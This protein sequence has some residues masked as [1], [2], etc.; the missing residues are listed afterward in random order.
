MIDQYSADAVRYWAASTGLGKDAI[1]SEEKIKIGS[2]LVTKIWNV[3]R[4][5]EQFLTH[6]NPP[7]FPSGLSPADQWILSRLQRLIERSTNLY[8]NYDYAT[9]KSEIETFFWTEFTDNYLE[10][11][12]QRLYERNGTGYESALYTLYTILLTLLKMF[13]PIMPFITE[14]IYLSIFYRIEKSQSI[15]SSDWPTIN[16]KFINEPAER[17]GEILMEVATF[18]R[19]YKSEKNI[20]LG[21]KLKYLRLTTDKDHIVKDLQ[22][23][24][25]DLLSVTRAERLEILSTTELDV[26]HHLS[27][28]AVSIQCEH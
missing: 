17:I 4:F 20:A 21:T 23:A 1:I 28:T 13:A 11:C 19:R 16:E 15:H 9:A 25:A 14:E 27:E 7:T 6:Y 22:S 8:E 3:A 18:V 2:R 24:S 10:M 12:K 5:A 26:Q